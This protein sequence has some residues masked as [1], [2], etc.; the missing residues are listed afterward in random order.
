MSIV[1]I[2]WLFDPQSYDGPHKAATMTELM[3]LRGDV[4]RQLAA[5]ETRWIAASEALEEASAA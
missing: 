3:K 4:E 1:F 5:A 2:A